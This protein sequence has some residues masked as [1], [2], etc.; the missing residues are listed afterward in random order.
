MG[1]SQLTALTSPLEERQ[2]ATLEQALTGL[3]PTQ[4][5]WVSGYL[6][7]HSALMAPAA[8]SARIAEPSADLDPTIKPALDPAL[9]GGLT[10]LYGSQTGNA[11]GL[12]E[13]LAGLAGTRGMQPRLVS[14]GDYRARDI[15]RERLLLILVSTH[16]EGE[17]PESALDLFNFLHGKRAPRLDA[18]R[19]AVLG[20]GDSSYEHFCATAK[21]FDAQLRSLGAQPLLDLQCCDVT[22]QDAAAD[23]SARALDL[24]EQ[25]IGDLAGQGSDG[26]LQ[27]P[28]A[29]VIPMHWAKSL[30]ASTTDAPLPSHPLVARLL[31][32]R[33]LTTADAVAEVHHLALGIE[34]ETL[35]FV[36]GDALAVWF[37][38]EPALVEAVLSAT[39]LDG[40]APVTVGGA[41]IALREA[42]SERLEL[43]RLHPTLVKRW[44][45]LTGT[46]LT[47]SAELHADAMA[48]LARLCEDGARLRQYAGSRQV[49]DL[50]EDH[51]RRLDAAS[52]AA[53][54][55][56]LSPRLYSIASSQAEIDDEI[57]LTVSLLRYPV[58][59]QERLG[60]ASGFLTQRLDEDAVLR[61]ELKPNPNFRLP[62]NGD[63]P[64]L[65]IGA[66]TGVA[67]YR[68]FLQERAARGERGR[69]WL[70]FG[71][72]HQ[73][74]DFL[75]Q[76]DWQS[77][78]QR[79]Q[80]TRVST[81]FSRDQADKRYVQHRL[82]EQGRDLYDWLREGA[83]LYVC[84]AT[85]MGQAVQEALGALIER[86]ASCDR[87]TA[88][89]HLD[90]LRRDGRYQR[91]L[92]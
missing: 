20:L 52:L 57:H 47:G 83:H 1:L 77:H 12:A 28:A 91:D 70:L 4:I 80:L 17:P 39:R 5:A 18:L 56:P 74:R 62:S 15:G 9:S 61:V 66:G 8:N 14:M 59:D 78:R 45:G 73:R 24:A 69:A 53:L 37:R 76:L 38:N 82:L 32:C 40:D 72:R 50:I 33:P 21:A 87:E 22:Y 11:Q 30:G 90:T 68:A 92:Y 71:N 46:D 75:Y 10:L 88:Q 85:A 43:T 86:E 7:A 6:A 31:E 44:S 23:W 79:G 19:F 89:D 35:R 2:L 29:N 27:R 65:M 26:T 81:A 63:T 55:Q 67:P 42:L 84:G 34:P 13:T 51:P 64:I 60:G 16:G 54:L 3:S 41:E 58:G 25:V 48:D 36:P 49:I